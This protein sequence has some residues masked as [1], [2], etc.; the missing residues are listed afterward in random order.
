MLDKTNESVPMPVEPVAE[1]L[2]KLLRMKPLNGFDFD[3]WAQ[4]RRDCTKLLKDH[5]P[6]IQEYGWTVLDVFGYMPKAPSESFGL[7]SIRFI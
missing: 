5:G 2:E 6:V 1:G 7:G 4:I 3:R